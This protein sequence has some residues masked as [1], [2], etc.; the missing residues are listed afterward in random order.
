MC[1]ASAHERSTVHPFNP[2]NTENGRC[3][4]KNGASKINKNKP[5]RK[6]KIN[7]KVSKSSRNTKKTNPKTIKGP[8]NPTCET[9]FVRNAG[10]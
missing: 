5:T 6:T 1:A 8:D 2:S 7:K 3:H 9:M 4:K 10:L